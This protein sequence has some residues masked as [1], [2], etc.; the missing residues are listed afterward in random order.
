[1]GDLFGRKRL[2]VIGGLMAAG[3]FIASSVPDVQVVWVGQVLA[4]SGAAALFP[5]PWPCRSR[6]RTP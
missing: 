5:P 2:L 1:M 4:G 6:A 3:E